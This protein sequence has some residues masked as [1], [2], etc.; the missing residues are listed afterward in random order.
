MWRSNTWATDPCHY[1]YNLEGQDY[2]ILSEQCNNL[3][4][5]KQL[6][7]LIMTKGGYKLTVLYMA[8][9]DKINIIYFKPR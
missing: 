4:T 8:S 3:L 1:I 6:N 7:R 9:N 2:Y 5:H